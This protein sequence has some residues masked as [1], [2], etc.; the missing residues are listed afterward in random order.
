MEE[1]ATAGREHA[2]AVRRGEQAAAQIVRNALSA[3]QSHAGR[4]D[5]SEADSEPERQGGWLGD[6]ER[7]ARVERA[8]QLAG[9]HAFFDTMKTLE[10]LDFPLSPRRLAALGLP[11]SRAVRSAATPPQSRPAHH[12]E[13]A[14]AEAVRESRDIATSPM[15]RVAIEETTAEVSTTPG[16]PDKLRAG[17]EQLARLVQSVQLQTDAPPLDRQWHPHAAAAELERQLAKQFVSRSALAQ[18]PVGD[19]SGCSTEDDGDAG[20]GSTPT[21]LP[22]SPSQPAVQRSPQSRDAGATIPEPDTRS[23]ATALSGSDGPDEDHEMDFWTKWQSRNLGSTAS[24]SD[25]PRITFALPATVMESGADANTK[26]DSP[27]VPAGSVPLPQPTRRMLEVQQ[28]LLA[29]RS[30]RLD[31]SQTVDM[32]KEAMLSWST[33]RGLDE[34]RLR[35]ALQRDIRSSEETL[36][37]FVSEAMHLDEQVAGSERHC[38]RILRGVE[39]PPTDEKWSMLSSQFEQLKLLP[40]QLKPPEDPDIHQS[41]F[42]RL[43]SSLLKDYSGDEAEA[44]AEFRAGVEAEQAKH[45]A[46]AKLEALQIAHATELAELRAEMAEMASAAATAATAAA[47]AAAT[48]TPS[49]AAASAE[50]DSAVHRV[51]DAPA[52]STGVVR[53]R[54]QRSGSSHAAEMDKLRREHSHQIAALERELRETEQAVEDATDA[55]R[56]EASSAR[57]LR[58]E[59][60]RLRIDT[61]QARMSA[62]DQHDAEISELRS[63]LAEAER[64]MSRAGSEGE[65]GRLR[66]ELSVVRRQMEI[67]LQQAEQG[68]LD[69]AI[70]LEA[71]LTESTMDVA[72]AAEKVRASERAAEQLQCELRESAALGHERLRAAEQLHAGEVMQLEMKLAAAETQ[73]VSVTLTQLAESGSSSENGHDPDSEVGTNVGQS[74]GPRRV[75]NVPGSAASSESLSAVDQTG[76]AGVRTFVG[77][78]DAET[79]QLLQHHSGGERRATSAG[80]SRTTQ[81]MIENYHRLMLTCKQ[82]CLEEVAALQAQHAAAMKDLESEHAVKLEAVESQAQQFQMQIDALQDTV[83][84]T[85]QSL[86][87]E[88]A[89][90]QKQHLQATLQTKEDHDATVLE[91]KEAHEKQMSDVQADAEYRCYRLEQELNK[92]MENQVAHDRAKEQELNERLDAARAEQDSILAEKEI[93]A[94]TVM[95]ENSDLVSQLAA[96]RKQSA[97]LRD[98]NVQIRSEHAASLAEHSAESKQE[99]DQLKSEAAAQRATIDELKREVDAHHTELQ[100]RVKQYEAE[101]AAQKQAAEQKLEALLEKT[102]EQVTEITNR[103]ATASV[104]S[105]RDATSSHAVGHNH[106]INVKAE[107]QVKIEGTDRKDQQMVDVLKQA[108]A[109]RRQFTGAQA[110]SGDTVPVPVLPVSASDSVSPPSLRPAVLPIDS[111]DAAVAEK[112]AAAERL[113]LLRMC[114]DENGCV[115]ASKCM[116][117]FEQHAQGILDGWG[118]SAAPFGRTNL[119]VG[120]VYVAQHGPSKPGSKYDEDDPRSVTCSVA[121]RLSLLLCACVCVAELDGRCASRTM[122]AVLS[123]PSAYVAQTRARCPCSKR[124][125]RVMPVCCSKNRQVMLQMSRRRSYSQSLDRLLIIRQLRHTLHG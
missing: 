60:S 121:H 39:A 82:N 91:L 68:R 46:E 6:R 47:A 94:A 61:E 34:Q 7:M 72:V 32:V 73:L 21:P 40:H 57:D 18:S 112:R 52:K 80:S 45:A 9:G 55:A 8:G 58:R 114:R 14:Q 85:Q 104:Q 106:P 109:V 105:P 99:R 28:M 86:A 123:V 44:E 87:V 78:G 122:D 100:A 53:S 27:G 36:R 50:V 64:G 33:E 16:Q 12:R 117:A 35:S 101:L 97:Q 77:A 103:F 41:V 90:L 115:Q 25:K 23:V 54:D 43:L 31:T 108:R 95:S 56:A 119:E 75:P 29:L 111:H 11:S 120:Q 22:S 89:S 70:R 110:S 92:Q 79:L 84:R 63:Q 10:A 48:A 2:A 51:S 19:G 74:S 38:E 113:S 71:K 62:R 81:L 118:Q 125:H 3:A 66:E 4:A 116:D 1:D 37:A 59:L 49:A 88:V 107:T 67:A 24:G 102:R 65:V 42:M 76:S 20:A 30:L 98:E 83:S 93:V 96:L 124:W 13:S 15:P 5:G 17:S 26:P 69:E